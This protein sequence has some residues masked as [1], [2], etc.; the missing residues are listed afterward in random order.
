M[1]NYA[2]RVTISRKVLYHGMSG[3]DE[4]ISGDEVVRPLETSVCF[5]VGPL[6]LF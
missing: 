6:K 3:I 1:Y 4:H 2:I 5:L